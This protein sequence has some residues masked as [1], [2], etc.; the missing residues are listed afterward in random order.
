MRFYL[1]GKQAQAIDKYTQE[2]LGIPGLTLM[3]SAAKKLAA[4]GEKN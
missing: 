4:E 1:T 2:T 3:E